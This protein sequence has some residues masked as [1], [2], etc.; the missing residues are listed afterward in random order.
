M[1]ECKVNDVK[2]AMEWAR[3]YVYGVV[4]RLCDTVVLLIVRS[5]GSICL[6]LGSGRG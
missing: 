3:R 4:H 2:R 6:Y 5:D 1:S